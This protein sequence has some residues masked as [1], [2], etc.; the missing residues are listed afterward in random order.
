MQA[1][2]EQGGGGHKNV[3]RGDT[4]IEGTD[5]DVT[6]K[7]AKISRGPLWS[8]HAH[9]QCK[10]MYSWMLTAAKHTMSE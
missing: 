5:G 1:L 9:I 6:H 10:S 3:S 2:G 4:Y 8:P 7:I